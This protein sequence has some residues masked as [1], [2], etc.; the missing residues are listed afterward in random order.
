MSKIRVFIVLLLAMPLLA[1]TAGAYLLPGQEFTPPSAPGIMVPMG[2]AGTGVSAGFSPV[3]DI[4]SSVTGF[5][6]TVPNVTYPSGSSLSGGSYSS[7]AFPSLQGCWDTINGLVTGMPD[8]NGLM[9]L[10]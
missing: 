3:V 7:G 9:L 2:M 6:V 10:A 1:M 8:V 4:P 5:S